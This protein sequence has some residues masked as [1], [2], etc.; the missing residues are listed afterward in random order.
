MKLKRPSHREITGKLASAEN[1]LSC[2][3]VA[4]LNADVIRED[5]L[6]LNILIE[7]LPELLPRMMDELSADLYRGTRPPQRSYENAI[8]G[9]ELYAF[10]WASQAVGC[11]M[12]LK[13]ALKN[14]WLW[15]VSFHED[16]KA[17]GGEPDGL[18][19]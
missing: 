8:D 7:D 3:H 10:A 4:L 2:G 9:C 6:D 19:N 14:E 17:K 18:P 15:V 5:L 1:A 13:F 11:D 12:Y 16:R